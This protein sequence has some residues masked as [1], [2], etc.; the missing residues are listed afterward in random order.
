MA[1]THCSLSIDTH[2]ESPGSQPELSRLEAANNG[3][4][5]DI[6]DDALAE[7]EINLS[8]VCTAEAVGQGSFG[9]GKFSG[10]L[11]S[12][13]FVEIFNV[14]S[15]RLNNLI[16]CLVY[17][18]RWH[19]DVAVKMLNSSCW[20]TDE[21]IEDFR[22]EVAMLRYDCLVGNQA[23]PA[24]MRSSLWLLLWKNSIFI[25]FCRSCRVSR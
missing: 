13:C 17:R 12:Q 24:L 4:D 3:L 23:Q 9:T 22:R 21:Q 8:D 10:F 15:M 2:G 7:F 5:D 6:A 11:S 14:N 20:P 1:A 16:S 19:G 25:L 18:G